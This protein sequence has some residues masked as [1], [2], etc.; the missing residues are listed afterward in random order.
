MQNILLSTASSSSLHTRAAYIGQLINAAEWCCDSKTGSEYWHTGRDVELHKNIKCTRYTVRMWYFS[1][2]KH[3][4]PGVSSLLLTTWTHSTVSNLTFAQYLT[5]LKAFK[6][7]CGRCR[8]GIKLKRAEVEEG[9]R[10]IQVY[11]A[12]QPSSLVSVH[13]NHVATVIQAPERVVLHALVQPLP[14]L[15]HCNKH[16]QQTETLPP[17]WTRCHSYCTAHYN[18]DCGRQTI[19]Q[20]FLT[21]AQFPWTHDIGVVSRSFQRVCLAVVPC[22]LASGLSAHGHWTCFAS[23]KST[24]K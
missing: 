7:C 21:T 22:A 5:W 11:L 16:V 15:A 13:M 4:L 18:P 19:R 24:C 20:P 12:A 3:C 9:R 10:L 17:A 1:E 8:K 6:S 2:R 14:R 23:P